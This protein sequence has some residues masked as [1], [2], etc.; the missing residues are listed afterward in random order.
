M[1]IKRLLMGL[2]LMGLIALAAF[3]TWMLW[4][5]SLSS[6]L[7]GSQPFHVSIVIDSQA[8]DG[9]THLIHPEQEIVTLEFS[10][11][12]PEGEAVNEIL[13][14]YSYHYCWDTLTGASAIDHGHGGA[15]SIYL[16]ESE[17]PDRELSVFGVSK[18]FVGET[19][20]ISGTRVYKI[21]YWGNGRAQALTQELAG[22]F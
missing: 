4:P 3:F 5:R 6:A 11:G 10:A 19:S 8:I 18:C 1:R 15:V 17:A 9:E 2:A 21:G 16:W 20:F 13:S 22:I 12:S 7:D 14:R